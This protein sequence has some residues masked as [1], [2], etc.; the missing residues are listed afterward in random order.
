MK[1]NDIEL[2]KICSRMKLTKGEKNYMNTKE[3]Y[4]KFLRIVSPYLKL[5]FFCKRI[6]LSQ[7]ALSK[8]MKSDIFDYEVSIEKL[9]A[10]YNDITGICDKIA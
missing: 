1:K 2:Q 4:R 6:G 5:S 8:F 3:D 10:L 9:N 7:S